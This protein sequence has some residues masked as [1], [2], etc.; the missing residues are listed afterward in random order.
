[1]LK[2]LAPVVGALGSRLA[3]LI[4]PESTL[5]VDADGREAVRGWAYGAISRRAVRRWAYGEIRKEAGRGWVYGSMNVGVLTSERLEADYH[6]DRVQGDSLN[7]CRQRGFMQCVSRRQL[8]ALRLI[9]NSNAEG[10]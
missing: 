2:P 6:F 4:A 1:M 8:E 9:R 10:G 3:D 5:Y 7:R